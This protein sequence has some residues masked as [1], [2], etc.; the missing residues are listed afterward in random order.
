MG[1]QQFDIRLLPVP[2]LLVPIEDLRNFVASNQ[3]HVRHA[4][5]AIDSAL[6]QIILNDVDL[7]TLLPEFV[8]IFIWSRRRFSM[9][10]LAKG[11][12][13]LVLPASRGMRSRLH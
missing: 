11:S 8:V 12:C 4:K 3:P 6:L 10:G 5:L 9:R 7:A 2:D 13:R 1:L